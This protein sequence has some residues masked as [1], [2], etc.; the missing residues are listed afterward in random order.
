MDFDYNK[1]AHIA[2]YSME[3]LPSYRKDLPYISNKKV[4]DILNLNGKVEVDREIINC[5]HLVSLF[6]LNSIDSYRSSKKVK[7]NELF[8]DED[9]IRRAVPGNF[10]EIYK[11]IIKNS[12]ARHVIACDKFGNFLHEIAS[13]THSGE[14]RFFILQ[15]CSHAMSFKVMHK[16]KKIEGVSTDRWVV[17][18]FDPNKT[19]VVSRSEVLNCNEFLDLSKFSL[20]MFI[21]K[22]SYKDYFGGPKSLGPVENECAI[23]EY[24][25]IREASLDFSTLETLSQDNISGCMIYH[26][27]SNNISSL[28][29]R[30]VVKYRS[31]LTLSANARKEIFFAKS[32]LGVSALQ[33]VMEQNYFNSMISY[34]D[35]LKELS[36][37]EELSLLPDIIHTKSPK[38]VPAL[39]MAMQDGNIECINNF[40]LLIKRLINIR[41]RLSVEKF[42]EILFN[43]LLSKRESG[44]SA[45]SIAISKNNAEA[46]LAFGNFFDSIFV[47]KDSIGSEKLSNIIFRLLSYTYNKRAPGL[48]SALQNG[49]F[50]TVIAFGGLV[51]KFS[52][53]R[54]SIPEFR[55]NS[56]MLNILMAVGGN[57]KLGIF[58][59]LIK[60]NTNVVTA[61]SSL[62]VY[63]SKEVRKEIFCVKYSN[64]YP[65]IYAL[66]FHNNPQSL[67]AYNYFLQALSCDEQM[68]L[69]PRL[70]ISKNDN[71]DPALFMAMQEGYA[72]C[73]D[74]YGV[75]I[76]K[77]LIKI[78]NR[79][80]PDDFANLV[81]SIVS[82]K[83][84]DGI[85]ALFMGMYNNRV[86]AIEAYSKLLDKVLSLLR[87]TISD[88]R[89]AD[90]IHAL[91]SYYSPSYDEGSIFTA[92]RRGHAGSVVAFGLLIDKLILMRGY[93]SHSKLVNMIFKLLKARTSTNIDGLFM[94]L[95]EGNTDSV[96]AFGVLLDRFIGMMGYV[97][98]VLLADM[99]FDLL[100]CKS[101]DN[102]ISG[103]FMAMQEGH[104]GTVDAFRKLLERTIIFKDY[105]LGEFFDNMLLDTIIS[106]RSDGISGLFAALKNNFPEVVKSYGRLLSLIPKD[107]LVNVLVAS[108]GFGIPAALFAGNEAL[109]SYF[110]IISDLPT[111]VI[112]ALYSRLKTI[113]RSIGHTLSGNSDLDGKYTILLE[114]AKEIARNSRHNR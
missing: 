29:I 20:R 96:A 79:M 14:Q 85:S 3:E 94:A 82:A 23:Y 70:L 32:S 75:L 104:H 30:G 27:M 72:D 73:I 90:I 92:L 21:K 19:N 89:L 66:I 100:M 103:L 39:F 101:G 42:S 7:I 88:D 95:Q 31:F 109:S 15:S 6:T 113:R 59:P 50:D 77:Q 41:H 18:F 49:H 58:I 48:F 24:S 35:F 99:V 93:V 67:T 54:H 111:N 110:E 34:D 43:V 1:H 84:S 106:R 108:D 4:G 37:D 91:I 87:G 68:D 26:M 16:P 60:N 107:E 11:N 55:F 69:L 74:A 13:T 10:R 44:C 47:L 62:L 105:I 64:G 9:S 102:N 46:I 5:S 45:L 40:A 114:R 83:R 80:S 57:N 97:E 12:C 51:S 22:C 36:Y 17:H 38:G 112:C 33:L 56:M 52:S 28:D 61:Y 81:L 53:L 71:G 98:D 78:R 8:Y 25:D 2:S 76:E 65:A 63:A 86:S